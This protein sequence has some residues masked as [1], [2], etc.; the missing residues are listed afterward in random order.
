MFF[1]N[2]I[3]NKSS[4]PSQRMG[5]IIKDLWTSDYMTQDLLGFVATN[6]E[7][8]YRCASGKKYAERN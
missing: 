2:L 1:K 5:K 7:N 6:I 8:I 3:K 4:L